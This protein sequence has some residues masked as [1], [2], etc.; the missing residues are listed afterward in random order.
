M[1]LRLHRAPFRHAVVD[2]AE[3]AGEVRITVNYQSDLDRVRAIFEDLYPR[4][5][6]FGLRDVL[7]WLGAHPLPDGA[8]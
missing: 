4:S 3:A 5:P 8:R 2:L 1:T 7:E 6:A